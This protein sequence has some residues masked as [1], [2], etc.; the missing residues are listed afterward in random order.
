MKLFAEHRDVEAECEHTFQCNLHE[1]AI[2]THL[3][4][5]DVCL[6]FDTVFEIVVQLLFETKST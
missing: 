3:D 4:M 6:G 5:N 1:Y 2:R